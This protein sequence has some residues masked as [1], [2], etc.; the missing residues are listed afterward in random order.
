M[1]RKFTQREVLDILKELGISMSRDRFRKLEI[2]GILP[3]EDLSS[4]RPRYHL[5]YRRTVQK[6][7]FIISKRPS[8][9]KE[10]SKEDID[11][12]IEKVVNDGMAYNIKTL[13]Y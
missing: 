13:N 6:I 8:Y 9:N 5:Y 10:I 11:T 2:D 3:S 12:A 4:T 7:A 1:R